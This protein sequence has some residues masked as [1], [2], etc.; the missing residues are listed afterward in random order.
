MAW[1]SRGTGTYYYQARRVNGRVIKEYVPPL[2]AE[3]VALLDAERRAKRKAADELKAQ[4]AALDALEA[5]LDPLNEL[6]DTLTHG[7][8]LTAGYHKHKGQWRR[9]RV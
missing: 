9:R 6:A 1:E 3:A 8:M 4:R 7:V 5:T 2:M